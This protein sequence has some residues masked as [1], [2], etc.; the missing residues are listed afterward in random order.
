MRAHDV[1][2]AK[3]PQKN[4]TKETGIGNHEGV[5]PCSPDRFRPRRCRMA[6][7]SKKYSAVPVVSRTVALCMGNR[8]VNRRYQGLTEMKAASCIESCNA[9]G[10]ENF[11][12]DL[13]CPR[14]FHQSN[15]LA[16]CNRVL[17]LPSDLMVE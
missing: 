6:S 14:W 15:T 9:I 3:E 13:R 5:C 2:P 7:Y 8:E 16:R 1:T 12:D 11:T 4:G 10:L 17:Q